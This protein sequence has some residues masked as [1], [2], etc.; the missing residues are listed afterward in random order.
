[1]YFANLWKAQRM[2]TSKMIVN[3]QTLT[4]AQLENFE[5]YIDEKPFLENVSENSWNEEFLL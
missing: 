5:P 4:I 1:M 3:E 2:T